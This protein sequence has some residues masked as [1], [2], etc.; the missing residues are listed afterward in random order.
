MRVGGEKGGLRGEVGWA[1]V[2]GMVVM[3]V[4]VVVDVCCWCL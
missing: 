1:R 4:V 2:E 3:V